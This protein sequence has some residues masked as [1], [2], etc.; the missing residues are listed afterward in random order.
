ML[1]GP[2][3]SR[4]LGW[5]SD[6]GPNF[7]LRQILEARFKRLDGHGRPWE[8]WVPRVPYSRAGRLNL[9]VRKLFSFSVSLPL[10]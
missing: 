10:K 1:H 7:L 6:S 3:Q 4:H 2:Y 8:T 5:K 9:Q